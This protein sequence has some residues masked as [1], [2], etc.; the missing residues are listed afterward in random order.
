MSV[1]LFISL[2]TLLVIGVFIQKFIT[3]Q[4]SKIHYGLIPEDAF[5]KSINKIRKIAID[6]IGTLFLISI[7][8]SPISNLLNGQL[9]VIKLN[10]IMFEFAIYYN[11]FIGLC[12]YFLLLLMAINSSFKKIM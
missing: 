9:P 8:I 10:P 11:V 6:L 1:K 7:G 12:S 5:N 3:K 2:L 4:F